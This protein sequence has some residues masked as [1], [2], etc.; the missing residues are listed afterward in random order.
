MLTVAPIIAFLATAKPARAKA[1]YRDTLKLKLTDEDDFALIFDAAGVMLR[2]VKVAQ[3]TIA[4][5]T[6]LGWQVNDI[7]ATMQTLRRR[8]VRF[9]RY[10]GMVQDKSGV[11]TAPSGAKIAWFKDPDGNT[12]SLTEFGG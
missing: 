7:A 11:W 6:V 10:K 3:P 4:P 9:H 1:F 2:V 5:Y 8:G 12:L